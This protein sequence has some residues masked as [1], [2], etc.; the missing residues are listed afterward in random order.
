MAIKNSLNNASSS[1][2]VTN[3]ITNTTGTVTLNSGTSVLSLSSDASAT[4][5]N[6]ATGNAVKTVTLGSTSSTSSLALKYGTNDFTLASATGTTMSALDTGEITYPLQSAF[7]AYLGSTVSNVTGAGATFT[8]GTTTAL[9]E[10]FDQNSDFN[11]NGTYTAPVTGRYYLT[12]SI[13]M[14]DLTA[15]MSSAAIRMNTSNRLY[16]VGT[17][18][19]GA[20][21]DAS[22]QVGFLIDLLGDMDLGDTATLQIVIASGVGDTADCT[23]SSDLLTYFCG[24]LAC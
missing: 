14:A 18:S 17:I 7:L 10:V 16:V 22:N 9:T 20:V 21:K 15:A 4:T 8:I 6:L 23:G 12:G 11:T 19:A 24:Y 5:V 2:A 3:G 13:Q 1:F